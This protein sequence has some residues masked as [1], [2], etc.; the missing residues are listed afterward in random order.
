MAKIF[1]PISQEEE[2]CQ[3][4]ATAWG[5]IEVNMK[6]REGGELGCEQGPLLEF[7]Q[8]TTGEGR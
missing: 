7:L 2:S 1:T 3:A 8:E 6:Q 4:M 5:I